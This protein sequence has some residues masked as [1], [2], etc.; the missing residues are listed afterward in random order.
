M[1]RIRSRGLDGEH[2]G[3]PPLLRKSKG[4]GGDFRAKS[5]NKSLFVVKG[6]DSTNKVLNQ[7]ASKVNELIVVNDEVG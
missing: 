5:C 7:E 6:N 2:A 4:N 1:K 3:K